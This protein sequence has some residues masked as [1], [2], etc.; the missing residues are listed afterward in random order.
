MAASELTANTASVGFSQ[1]NYP[2]NRWAALDRGAPIQKLIHSP[3]RIPVAPKINGTC[4]SQIL[5]L[6]WHSCLMLSL[7]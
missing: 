7:I 5:N 3:R 1:R 4:Q 2:K 6:R